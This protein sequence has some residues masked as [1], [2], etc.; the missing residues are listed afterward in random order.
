MNTAVLN[1][2][3]DELILFP[4]TNLGKKNTRTYM[5]DI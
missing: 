1:N 4:S 5:I 3:S 2:I